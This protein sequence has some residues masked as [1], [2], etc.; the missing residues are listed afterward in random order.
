[1]G[2]IRGYVELCGQ[3]KRAMLGPVFGGTELGFS[4]PKIELNAESA[5]E[6][7]NGGDVPG[8]AGQRASAKTVHV[9]VIGNIS[10]NHFCGLQGKQGGGGRGCNGSLSRGASRSRSPDSFQ[11][12]VPNTLGE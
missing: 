3:G 10:D 7:R 12:S 6:V 5:I 1:M 9:H 8:I 2:T 4:S 11:V